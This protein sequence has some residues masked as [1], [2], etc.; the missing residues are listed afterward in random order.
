MDFVLEKTMQQVNELDTREEY[1]ND[2][3]KAS[4]L[5]H[6][7]TNQPD[8]ITNIT[9]EYLSNSDHKIVKFRKHN[10]DKNV[11]QDNT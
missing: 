5:D 10:K 8:L 1:Q 3:L 11:K 4:N 7:Y 2:V 6:V 9:A